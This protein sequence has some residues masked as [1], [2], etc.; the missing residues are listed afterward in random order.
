M[1]TRGDRPDGEPNRTEPNRTE[2]NR[3][4]PP[5]VAAI[6]ITRAR[7]RAMVATERQPLIGASASR[8]DG[9]DV[10]ARTAATEEDAGST[11]LLTSRSRWVFTVFKAA[12]A[13]TLL[14]M[15]AFMGSS[16]VLSRR[17]GGAIT[18]REYGPTLMTLAWN[19]KLGF[20]LHVPKA[21]SGLHT[22]A[23]AGKDF[24]ASTIERYYPSR[25]APGSPPFHVFFEVNDSPVTGCMGRRGRSRCH[26]ESW[27]PIFAFGSSPKNPSVMP[28]MRSATLIALG[29]CI[30]PHKAVSPSGNMTVTKDTEPL[31]EFLEYPKHVEDMSQCDRSAGAKAFTCRYYG[32]FNMDAMVNKEEYKWDNLIPKAI[33]RGSDYH[34]YQRGDPGAKPEALHFIGQIGAAPDKKAAMRALLAGSAIGPR[35]R[36]V[37]MSQLNPDLIDAKF[38]NWN[39]RRTGTHFGLVTTDHIEEDIMGKYKYQLDLGGGGGTT[40]SGVIP[41]LSMPGVLFHHETAMK[42]SYFD[43]LKPY[44]HYLPLKEDLSNFEELVRFVETNPTEAQAISQRASDWVRE[45]RKLGSLLRHNYDVLAVPLAKSLDP[46]GELKLAPIPFEQAHPE[47]AR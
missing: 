13:I 4:E 18:A 31:C 5:R 27:E 43:Q 42:D 3:T 21:S 9:G 38:F 34:F 26:P 24:I 1:G 32:L 33:W 36:A 35:L 7:R 15:L 44:V 30:L 45:F 46:T 10:S 11:P 16:E 2:P 12:F 17:R 22:R 14:A 23:H 37:F 19:S 28:S 41:K 20:T 29:G 40:W 6:H 39:K 47:L 25:I 8:D